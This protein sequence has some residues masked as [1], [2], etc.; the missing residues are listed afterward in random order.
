MRNERR[1]DVNK[2]RNDRQLAAFQSDPQAG[3]GHVTDREDRHAACSTP[4]SGQR[5][6][7]TEVECWTEGD[8][9]A[10]PSRYIIT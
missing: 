1:N 8:D 2:T 5:G 9:M 6:P 7:Q 4:E 3:G 10:E